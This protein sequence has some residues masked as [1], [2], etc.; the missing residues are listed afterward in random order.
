NAGHSATGGGV[1]RC[2]GDDNDLRQFKA[3]S[4]AV[5]C[6]IGALPGTLQ[7]RSIIIKLTRAKPGE[8]EIRFDP[9]FVEAEKV[10]CRKLARWCKDN[11]DRI[12]AIDPTL[13]EKA[14]N[15]LADN[16]RP[17]F[18]IAEIAQGDWPEFCAKAFEYLTGGNEDDTDGTRLH[19][20]ADIKE[21]L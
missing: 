8:V 4:P 13:P 5:L 1:L 18:K 17:L 14:H 3:H 10:L 7:D 15:R 19:L 11:R 21:I 6:G 16:W 20:L 2:V 12:S 9:A